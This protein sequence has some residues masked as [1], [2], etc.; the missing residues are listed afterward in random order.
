MGYWG[1]CGCCCCDPRGWG[2]GCADARSFRTLLMSATECVAPSRAA[3]TRSQAVSHRDSSWGDCPTGAGP[4]GT[5]WRSPAGRPCPSPGGGAARL[6]PWHMAESLRMLW[7]TGGA[8]RSKVSGSGASQGSLARTLA[9]P[10]RRL[11]S[12]TQIHTRIHNHTKRKWTAWDDAQML[13]CPID[14]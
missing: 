9:T 5:A 3:C 14:L 12:Q 11:C 4:P 1:C 2:W 6:K 13:S 8:G 10:L 7:E